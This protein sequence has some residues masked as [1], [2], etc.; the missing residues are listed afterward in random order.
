MLLKVLWCTRQPPLQRLI[1]APSVDSDRI[2]KTCA[3]HTPAQ[4]GA[5]L[6]E[7]PGAGAFERHS[8]LACC[9]G[10]PQGVAEELAWL[11]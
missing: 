2:E 6:S 7:L 10:T 11:C 1:W 8:S 3:H 9:L 5:R 4:Y